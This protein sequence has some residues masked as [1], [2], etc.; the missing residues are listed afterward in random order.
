M[1]RLVWI[2]LVTTW[3]VDAVTGQLVSASIVL[4]FP[5]VC[6]TF[7]KAVFC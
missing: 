5:A 3:I 6:F 1:K 4:H 2:S 7:G